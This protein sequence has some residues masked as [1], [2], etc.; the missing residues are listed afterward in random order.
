MLYSLPSAI[1]ARS[2]SAIF[3]GVSVADCT[4]STFCCDSFSRYPPAELAHH[5]I[6]RG[7]DGAAVA[8]MRLD[9]LAFPFRIEQIGKAFRRLFALHQLGI[10][11]DHAQRRAQRRVEPVR[12]AMRGRNMFGDV[13]GHVGRQHVLPL[14]RQELRGVAGVDGIDRVD[15]AGIFLADAGEDA[16]GAG[17]LDPRRD[18]G[19]SARRLCRPTRPAAGRPRCTRPPGLPASPP[20]S[21]RA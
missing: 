20:R 6:G 19:I 9:D 3:F 4:C 2:P 21:T 13:L 15:A 18:A 1:T 17:A 14:P 7:D 16:L 12:I 8:R 11:G 10:V 5:L